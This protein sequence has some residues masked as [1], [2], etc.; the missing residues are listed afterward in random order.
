MPLTA[1]GSEVFVTT[2]TTFLFGSYDYLEETLTHTNSLKLKGYPGENIKD[3]CEAILVDSERLEIAGV[4]KLEHLGYIIRIFEDTY[5]Y[6]FRLWY[7]NNYKEVTEFIKKR[8]VC[9]IDVVLQ[10]YLI[11]YE[12]LVQEATREYHDLVYSK[13]WEPAT[14]K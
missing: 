7:I 9:N 8:C 13:R 11:T 14:S 3:L 4:F 5:D 1:T 2:M 10:E 12:S 6:R